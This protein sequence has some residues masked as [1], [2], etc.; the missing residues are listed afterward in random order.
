TRPDPATGWRL[1]PWEPAWGRPAHLSAIDAVR[2]AIARGDVYQVNLVG[3]ASAAYLGD[4]APALRRVAALAGARYGGLLSGT[5]WAVSGWPV[6]SGWPPCCGPCAP[7]A[8]SPER[9]SSPRST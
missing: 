5:G 3:Y 9:R 7:G 6:T 1:G 4:P 2:R 8:R